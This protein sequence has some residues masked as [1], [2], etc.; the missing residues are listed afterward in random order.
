MVDANIYGW[1]YTEF[2]V[3]FGWDMDGQPKYEAWE[4]YWSR[5]VDTYIFNNSA[6]TPRLTGEEAIDIGDLVNKMMAQ[7]N[8]YLKGETVENPMTMGMLEPPRFP[9]F[10]GNPKGNGGIGTEDYLILNKL[11]RKYSEI[12]VK[13]FRLGPIP[14]DNPFYQDRLE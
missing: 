9:R 1:T 10:E 5:K 14:S 7:M 4:N 8:I 2:N 3:A 13:S 12:R 6:T 11:K